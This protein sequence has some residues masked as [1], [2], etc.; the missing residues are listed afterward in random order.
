MNMK[1]D[2]V[3]CLAI[4]SGKRTIIR[5]RRRQTRR[6][7]GRGSADVYVE[8]EEHV[9]RNAIL[10][11]TRSNQTDAVRLQGEPPGVSHGHYDSSSRRRARL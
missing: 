10:D 1:R 2:N 8:Q 3:C 11:G 7:W 9:R 6:F 5:A 4:F